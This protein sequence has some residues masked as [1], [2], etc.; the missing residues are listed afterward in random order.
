VRRQLESLAAAGAFDAMGLDRAVVHAAAETI[1]AVAAKAA[2]QRESGQGGLFGGDAAPHADVPLQDVKW[3]AI[4]RMAQEKEAFGF[5][6]SAH[7][8]DRYRALAS[9][10]GVRS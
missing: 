7:P 10:M 6:Y 9:G 4:E 8:V 3:A 2:E 1:L 5:Y